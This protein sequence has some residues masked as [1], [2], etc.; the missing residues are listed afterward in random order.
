MR[1]A[2][3]L[4]DAEPSNLTHH[5]NPPHHNVASFIVSR[6]MR[7][8][9]TQVHGMAPAVC[10]ALPP[11]QD[12]FEQEMTALQ[13]HASLVN[14]VALVTK[15]LSFLTQPDPSAADRNVLARGAMSGAA[16]VQATPP[17]IARCLALAHASHGAAPA[18]SAISLAVGTAKTAASALGLAYDMAA[19]SGLGPTLRQTFLSPDSVLACLSA[20]F[21]ALHATR[22]L[23]RSRMEPLDRKS[24][25]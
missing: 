25:V 13:G 11:P 15:S 17:F 5:P 24:V 2:V 10:N 6:R 1:G 7:G 22:Q 3:F 23:S 16:A 18:S 21:G 4:V 20:F 9:A 8:L 19:H 14:L 12:A